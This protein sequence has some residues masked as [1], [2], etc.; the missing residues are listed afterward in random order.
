MAKT[1]IIKSTPPKFH[2][3]VRVVRPTVT[4]SRPR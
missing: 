3:R 4:V 2:P 1:R